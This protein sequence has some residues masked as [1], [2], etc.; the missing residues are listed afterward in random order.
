MA[1]SAMERSTVRERKIKIV[2]EFILNDSISIVE[3]APIVLFLMDVMK[4]AS[5]S[6]KILVGRQ[7][8]SND[9]RTGEELENKANIK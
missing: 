6:I 3:R 7:K 5:S 2:F 8:T 4:E 9:R 1:A